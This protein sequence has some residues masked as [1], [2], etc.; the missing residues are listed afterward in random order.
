M[1]VALFISEEEKGAAGVEKPVWKKQPSDR[2]K[3][4]PE[5]L[6]AYSLVFP[7]R[8]GGQGKNPPADKQGYKKHKQKTGVMYALGATGPADRI[9]GPSGKG[10]I[11]DY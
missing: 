10:R 4:R 2:S 1:R 3:F 7:V 11:N 5:L 8:S 6:Y 9:S